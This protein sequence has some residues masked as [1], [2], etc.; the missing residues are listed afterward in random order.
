[1]IN[2]KTKPS[3]W[4]YAL[5]ALIPLFGCL[6]AAVIFYPGAKKL[7]ASIAKAHDLDRLTQIIVTGS[8]DLSL[9]RT[10]AY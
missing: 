2:Q 5:A 8:A 3:S 1:M 10:G 7:P 6:I 4:Y 9:S